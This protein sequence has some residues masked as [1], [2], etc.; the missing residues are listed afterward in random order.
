MREKPLFKYVSWF[1]LASVFLVLCNGVCSTAHALESQISTLQDSAGTDVAASVGSPCCPDDHHDSD[2]PACDDCV[3][4]LCHVTVAP[5]LFRLNYLPV[6]S[7]LSTFTSFRLIP[8]V[9]MPK[10]IPPQNLA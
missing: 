7:D 5:Q 8:E 2:S 10:F 4:C 6:F 9:Y 3:N 1:I